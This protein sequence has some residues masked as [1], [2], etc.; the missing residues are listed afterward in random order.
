MITVQVKVYRSSGFTL[1]EMAIV[2]ALIGLILGTG[3]TLLSAQQEQ[4]KIEETNALLSDAREALIGFA[5]SSPVHPYLPCPDKTTAAGA[6]TANDGL[7]DRIAG[8][9]VTQEGNLPWVTLGMSPQTDSWINRLRYRVSATFSNSTTGMLL[10]STG[11]INVLDT[12][13]GATIANNV[14]AVILSHG[15][16]GLGAT[17]ALCNPAL[18]NANPAPPVASSDELANTD[19]NT[20]FVSHSL[21]PAGAPGGAFDDQVTWISPY[22]LFN[23]MV[24]AGKLP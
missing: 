14:P 2:L 3:L 8:A 9:C 24:Q 1:V 5:I 20:V 16:N 21:A 7:E 10:T 12:V 23:R 13:G 19:G 22:I 15:H 4:R 6:G 11:D 18:C 17:N